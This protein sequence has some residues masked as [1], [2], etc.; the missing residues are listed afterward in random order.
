MRFA[1]AIIPLTPKKIECVC[2]D[3]DRLTFEDIVVDYASAKEKALER[4]IFTL[5]PVLFHERS[6][7]FE[8]LR[9]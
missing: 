9:I 3:V 6:R 7:L 8:R 2:G 1:S 4:A 5:V